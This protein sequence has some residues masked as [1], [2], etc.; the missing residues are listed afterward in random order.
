MYFVY[1]SD[2]Y[3][4]SDSKRKSVSYHRPP[5]SAHPNALQITM[6]SSSFRPYTPGVNP[7]EIHKLFVLI[8]GRRHIELRDPEIEWVNF[9][10]AQNT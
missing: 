5:S 8:D 9:M 6:A 2:S 10:L 3:F 1:A 4:T 7:E